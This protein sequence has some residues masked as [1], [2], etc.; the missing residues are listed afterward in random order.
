MRRPG[1]RSSRIT[2]SAMGPLKK[3]ARCFR[4]VDPHRRGN[5]ERRGLGRER[6]H[7]PSSL[8]GMWHRHAAVPRARLWGD[9]VSRSDVMIGFEGD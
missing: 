9:Q 1:Y 8:P 5:Q 3:V 4:A 6:A 2:T 7:A